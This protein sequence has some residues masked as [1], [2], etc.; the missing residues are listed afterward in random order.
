MGTIDLNYNQLQK[1]DG[2][3]HVGGISLHGFTTKDLKEDLQK[4]NKDAKKR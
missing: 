2:N 1:V 4:K 3:L